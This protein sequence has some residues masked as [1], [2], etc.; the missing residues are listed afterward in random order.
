VLKRN[1]SGVFN[2]NF[3]LAMVLRELDLEVMFY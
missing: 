2:G 3:S 1:S